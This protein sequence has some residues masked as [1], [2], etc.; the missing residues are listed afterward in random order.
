MLAEDEIRLAW[1]AHCDGHKGMRDSLL[2]LAV[3]DGGL[4]DVVWVER[5]RRWLVARRPDHLYAAFPTLG[6]ALADGRVS[7]A[8]ERVRRTFPPVRVRH[9]LLRSDASQGPYTG[10]REPL[11]AVLDDILGPSI[12]RPP[13]RVKPSR[14]RAASL[15]RGPRR[16]NPASRPTRSTAPVGAVPTSAAVSPGDQA[17]LLAMAF[18]LA[19]ALGRAD[20]GT[21]AA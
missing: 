19:L 18:L 9:L 12:P 4:D 15:A 17:L 20:E 7:E 3:A 6:R 21:R 11:G 14:T 10:R 5:C 2:T 1:Q 13:R 8:L 16:L